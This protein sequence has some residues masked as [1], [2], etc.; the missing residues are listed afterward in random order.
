MSKYISFL[1]FIFFVI[2]VSGQ[3]LFY[4]GS[5]LI[6]NYLPAE[7]NASSQNWS[8]I[9]DNRGIMYFGNTESVME[10][11]GTTWKKIRLPDLK[12]AQSIDIDQNGAIFVG[13]VGE[14][15]YLAC[16]HLGETEYVSLNNLIPDEEKDFQ[17]I[18]RT[19]AI[20]S[21]VYFFTP[22]RIFRYYD[23][24][25]TVQNCLMEAMFG[26]KAYDNLFVLKK[27]EGLFV[28]QDGE[29]ILLPH[30]EI[31]NSEHRM[32]Q[33]IEF[34]SNKLLIGTRNDGLYTYDLSY[35]YSNGTYNFNK[36]DVPE[37]VLFKL[38]TD[39]TSY[40][41]IN[42][43]YSAV[44]IND[45]NFAFG[46]V[47]GGIIITD[48]T[49]KCKRI[50]N[51]DKGLNNN[52]VYCLYTDYT[53][54]LWA[55]LQQGIARIDINY[56]LSY[57]NEEKNN[58]F[59]Y[60]TNSLDF[61]NDFFIGTMSGAFKFPADYSIIS[62]ENPEFEKLNDEIQEFWGFD[63]FDDILF[64][65][66]NKIY[67]LYNN[68][69]IPILI[70]N[71][72]SIHKSD[73][74]EKILFVGFEN[75]FKAY[76]IITDTDNKISLKELKNFEVIK[77]KVISIHE[78]K[79]GN[80]W[81]ETNYDG[82]YIMNFHDN[83]S[84]YSISHYT[85]KD[86]LPFDEYNFI[87]II[88]EQILVSTRKGVYEPVLI[89]DS[90]KFVQSDFFGSYENIDS[91]PIAQIIPFGKKF[92][93]GSAAEKLI[94]VD[95][96]NKD[97]IIYNSIF[98]KRFPNS[99]KVSLLDQNLIL[100]YTSQGLYVYNT[101]VE[102]NLEHEF[103]SYIRKVH[104]KNDSILFSGNYYNQ[105]NS[106]DSVFDVFTLTQPQTL[107]PK[108]DYTN[109]SLVFEYSSG[110][111]ED[112]DKTTYSYIL[113]GF[114]KEWSTQTF[115][116]KAVY[117]N[118]PEGT[119]K[120][121]VKAINIYGVES[122]IAEYQFSISPPW[123]RTIWAYISYAIVFILFFVLVIKLYTKRLEAKNKELEKIVQ[124]RTSEIMLQKEEIQAQAE[125]LEVTNKELEKLSIVASETDNA[126]VIA[127]KDGNIEWI[128]HAFTRLYG[129]SLQEFIRQA[130]ANFIEASNNTE[131]QEVFK[132]CIT[133]KKSVIYES[134]SNAKN[135]RNI[136]VQ[137]TITPILDHNGEIYKLIAIDS[138]IRK[139]K[140]AE[141]EILQKSEE[142][143]C[144]NEEI[145]AQNDEILAKNTL[146]E[147]QNF[148]IK[149][150][151]EL[152][153]GSIRYAKT[154]QNAIL[155]Y[156]DELDAIFENF[157]IFMPKDIVSGDFYW[158]T[159]TDK[160]HFFAVVD[161]TGHG[162]PG[163]FMSLIANT[164]LTEIVKVKKIFE[165]DL[166]L[167]ELDISIKSALRQEQTGNTDGMD[168]TFCRFENDK[169]N[170]IIQFSGAKNNLFY[171]KNNSN[172][173]EILKADRKSI[174]GILLRKSK[175]EFTSQQITL[176]K[177]SHIYLASD[178]FVDQ[179]NVDRKKFGTNYF[180]SLISQNVQK[181][182]NEQYNV[183]YVALKL[184]MS[185]TEQRDDIT[186]VG[187]KI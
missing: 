182:I 158:Y 10:F 26:F 14:F 165:T 84:N 124:E 41:A 179:N 87:D 94:I 52:C 81:L 47:N 5:P 6:Q 53:G 166:V 60:V 71:G 16:N 176:E 34:S 99:Y 36:K 97:S 35:F 127:D 153:K 79:E 13:S 25:I 24:Q 82:I 98:S 150:K 9:Q 28:M 54:N 181:P 72:Y 88:D 21:G 110:F 108:L 12:P 11:D 141:Q 148:E 125:E 56:P 8:I 67:Q 18:W 38:E 42:S 168:A 96:S 175:L 171:V 154:I 185:G 138:D 139:L 7:Y 135:G 155:P 180:I 77:E 120:F 51:K 167:K 152:I 122:V 76:E 103:N 70:E 1:L 160:Y 74:F 3:T 186:L 147:T 89:N 136:W 101:E 19:I 118:I 130:G 117:T 27:D 134:E 104:L 46:T 59:G 113:E 107:I 161:C 80:L 78:D 30:T 184:W 109:N 63:Y 29:L 114:E 121:R 112:A 106:K 40:L 151:N 140:Q 86:G 133:T 64:A 50:I 105:T 31:F 172:Q 170:W 62:G 4:S 17:N 146:I 22:D 111:Y 95:K 57:F 43:L 187:I 20:S 58:L 183:F 91:F 32:Y 177:G 119:Y 137:T 162:V 66:G 15:G 149:E 65:I 129:Y 75:S 126:I 73:K 33:I 2:K 49:G 100:I 144:Q 178:G 39:V 55:G 157:I 142:I 163:A 68:Q 23:N 174:G 37:D 131:I 128:N 69:L 44:K 102:N 159:K 83:L 115:D 61:N 173:V 123:Y 169:N 45:N 116:K 145:M 164:L 48:E 132:K 156:Q 90:I 143:M 92:L 93:V 85:T